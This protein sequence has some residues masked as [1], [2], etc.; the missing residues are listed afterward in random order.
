MASHSGSGT[1]HL[2]QGLL[3]EN[4]PLLSDLYALAQSVKNLPGGSVRT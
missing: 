1:A 2:P 4:L 3:Q